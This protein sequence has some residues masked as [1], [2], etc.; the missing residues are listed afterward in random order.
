MTAHS[1][2]V[3]QQLLPFVTFAFVASITPGPSNLLVLGNSTRYGFVAALPIVWGSCVGAAS[4]VLV[5]GFGMGRWLSEHP[6]IQAAMGW[7]GAIWMSILAWQIVSQ[8]V[9]TVHSA[10]DKPTDG[11]TAA[12]LQVVNPKTW[13]MA[14]AVVGVFAEESADIG[15]YALLSG[16][17]LLVSLPCLE[18]WAALGSRAATHVR[19]PK[20]TRALNLALGVALL[21][22]AWIGVLEHG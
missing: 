20:V 15:R 18:I 8:P 16:V 9:G 6:G 5:V 13:G 10:A 21:G 17:F 4:L 14:I 22:S 1:M 2:T 19:S 3:V 12:A 11:M 7:A